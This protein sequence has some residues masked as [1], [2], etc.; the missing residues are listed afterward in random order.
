MNRLR[1]NKA[2]FPVSVLGPG[3][4]IGIW[5]QGCSIGCKNCISRDTWDKNDGADVDVGILVDWCRDV[6][7]NQRFD[8]FTISGGE[9]FD[10]AEGLRALCN[11]LD[12]WRNEAGID[13]DILC[14]SGYP[15]KVLQRRFSEVLTQL[16]AI[17]PE[18]YISGAGGEALWRGSK[19]QPLIALSERGNRIVLEAERNPEDKRI[20]VDVSEGRIWFIGV[21]GSGDMDRMETMAAVHGL[22]LSGVSWRP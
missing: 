17:C 18:P 16:D 21:P 15:M 22:R 1:I 3:Q 13:F 20:Q 10:Q 14:Y 12:S 2:H 4:R 8:G 19:N 9:P 11:E 5:F 6:V 7:G